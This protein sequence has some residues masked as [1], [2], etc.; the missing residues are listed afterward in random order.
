LKL[1]TAK[2]TDTDQINGHPVGD[3][4]P[5]DTIWPKHFGCQE[6]SVKDEV[7]DEDTHNREATI[8]DDIEI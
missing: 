8:M 7:L 3:S 2:I 6:T 5:L 4:G 1:A